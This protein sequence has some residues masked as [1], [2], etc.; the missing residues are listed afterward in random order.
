MKFILFKWSRKKSHIN[1]YHIAIVFCDVF[2][3]LMRYQK[4]FKALNKQTSNIFHMT[5]L[6]NK[7]L[8]MW[9]FN[10][11]KTTNIHS[12]KNWVYIANKKRSNKRQKQIILKK[13]L[14]LCIFVSSITTSVHGFN[15]I[16]STKMCAKFVSLEGTDLFIFK[17]W[18][19]TKSNIF[20]LQKF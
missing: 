2:S 5:Q 16:K 14:R 15:N 13:M 4:T 3:L 19:H 11:T 10:M 17:Q 18:F 12:I 7:I 8:H 1:I 20:F 9:I 6:I